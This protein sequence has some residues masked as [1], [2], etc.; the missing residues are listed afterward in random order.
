MT[1]SARCDERECA[2]RRRH[3][4]VSWGILGMIRPW[5]ERRWFSDM[6]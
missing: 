2:A 4:R 6:G 3:I 1:G 5:M